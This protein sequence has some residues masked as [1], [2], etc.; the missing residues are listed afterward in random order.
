MYVI[1]NERN[2]FQFEIRGKTKE[3]DCNECIFQ[4]NNCKT[5]CQRLL[6]YIREGKIN[7]IIIP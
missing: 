2:N 7:G 1:I 6:H 4:R 3:L 5:I